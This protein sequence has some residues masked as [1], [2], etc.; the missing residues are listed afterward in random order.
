MNGR[1]YSP[2]F[3][4]VR[5]LQPVSPIGNAASNLVA[6]MFA[7]PVVIES[8]LNRS[9]RRSVLFPP[10]PV[11]V[12]FANPESPKQEVSIVHQL[13]QPT[14]NI[15]SHGPS[16]IIKNTARFKTSNYVEIFVSNDEKTR[17]YKL[18]Y[19]HNGFSRVNAP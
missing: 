6:C 7:G 3:L 17:T 12:T 11:R 14:F 19:G 10:S 5:W 18:Y 16:E 4:K 8:G 2:S 9:L 1:A 15:P 13:A